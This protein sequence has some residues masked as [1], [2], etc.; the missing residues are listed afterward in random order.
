LRLLAA[1]EAQE[2][3]GREHFM[4]AA[5]EAM[6]RILVD[7][8]RHRKRGK[9]G[10]GMLHVELGPEDAAVDVEIERVVEIDD[11]LSRLDAIDARA[12]DVV[13]LRYFAGLS[14]E[15][16]ATTLGVAERSVKRDWAFARAWLYR[17]LHAG[18]ST[19]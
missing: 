17:A 14:V 12:A 8:A 1:N 16:T 4:I 3:E 10:A 18:E 13:R 7:H 15:E 5:A 6:R 9:R 19:P 2:W 11:A